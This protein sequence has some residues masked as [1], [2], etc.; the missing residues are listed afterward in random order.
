MK[1]I[2]G[3]V[4]ADESVV[5]NAIIPDDKESVESRDDIWEL[6]KHTTILVANKTECNEKRIIG[7]E[8]PERHTSYPHI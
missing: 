5:T 8:P 6:S 2:V 4:V 1:L 3:A 7:N